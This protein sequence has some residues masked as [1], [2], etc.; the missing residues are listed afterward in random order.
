MKLTKVVC[1]KAV[2]EG[3][4][5][6]GFY[7]VRDDS[8]KGFGLRITPSGTKSFIITYRIGGRLRIH[9]LGRYGVLTVDEARRL[10]RQRLAGVLQ[11]E[12]PA[13]AKQKSILGD[14][15]KDLCA[16]YMEKKAL[17]EKKSWRQDFARI[18]RYII[19]ELGN[20]KIEGIRRADMK[21]LHQK[22]GD[23][24][25]YQA[26]R[27]LALL[28][29]MFKFASRFGM[30][31]EA[32]LNP[33]A[34]VEQFRE[35]ARDRW[36][37]HEEM[38]RLWAAIEEEPN[39]YIRAALQLF[40][41]CGLRK[42]ELLSLEWANVSL[43]RKEIHLD[44]TKAGRSFVLPLSDYAVEILHSLPREAG[45]PY[46]FVS[47]VNPGNHLVDIKRSWN[48]IRRKTGLHNVRL[49]D[50]RRTCGSWLASSGKSLPLIGRVLNQT[51]Q[52]VTA[53]YSR[54]AQ[55]PVREALQEHSEKVVS[56]VSLREDK[57][58]T[59]GPAK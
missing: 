12:D 41:L 22:I 26:N 23:K 59:E 8:V 25:K 27:V 32:F 2:Y 3:K 33:C 11:G 16:V 51:S 21:A 30:V 58:G 29:A 57:T 18:Q 38:P 20:R 6:K 34:G 45:N 56:I 9:T 39:P 44:D 49:H 52:S 55:D 4:G 7:A 43:E 40:I 47:G 53:V 17:P 5:G 19:P 1:D 24:G 54:L 48:R 37:T 15:V 13:E 36:V 28:S 10:A 35:K 31:S 42:N 46:V 50:L 14:T